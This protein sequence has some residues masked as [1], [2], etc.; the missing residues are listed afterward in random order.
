MIVSSPQKVDLSKPKGHMVQMCQTMDKPWQ[1]SRHL[2]RL[3]L[4]TLEML[5]SELN[6]VIGTFLA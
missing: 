4:P 2:K 5:F 3:F 1:I 6:G